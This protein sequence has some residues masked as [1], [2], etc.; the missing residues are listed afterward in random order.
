MKAG[1][2]FCLSQHSKSVFY[3]FWMSKKNQEKSY[4]FQEKIYIQDLTKK[5]IIEKSYLDRMPIN[6]NI[7]HDQAPAEAVV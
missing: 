5:P 3:I 6:Q 1:G 4:R 7:F 2:G